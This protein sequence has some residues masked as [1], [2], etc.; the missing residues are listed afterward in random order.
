MMWLLWLATIGCFACVFL[1]IWIGLQDHQFEEININQWLNMRYQRAAKGTTQAVKF[2]RF[3]LLT[4]GSFCGGIAVFCGIRELTQG[5]FLAIP[6]AI[7][8]WLIP[9]I[10]S[11][12]TIQRYWDCFDNQLPD[13]IGVLVSTARGGLSLQRGIAEVGERMP[14]PI[15]PE[16]QKISREVEVLNY[17]LAKALTLAR[18]RIP[19][20]SFTM[21][22]TALIIHLSRGG[23]VLGLLERISDSLR[24]LTR[25]RNKIITE[26]AGVRLQEKVVLALTPVFLGLMFFFDSSIPDLLLHTL[27][28]NVLLGFV[29]LIQ[30]ASVVWI[31]QILRQTL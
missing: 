15:G 18:E 16:F 9:E 22:S 10:W 21:V 19:T 7:G 5:I 14:A 13:A 23:D 3:R 25:L 27:A 11:R 8:V 20:E 26:T 6:A 30:L 31:R 2:T 1:V 12:M 29:F 24:E 4:I 28:G 17:P